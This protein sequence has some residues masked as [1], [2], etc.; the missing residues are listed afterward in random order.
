M[1]P[2][3]RRSRFAP[4]ERERYRVNN[5]IRIKEV[6]LIGPDGEQIGPTPTAEA[7]KLAREADMDLVEV[8]PNSRP[9]VCKIIDYGRFKYEQKKKQTRSRS[10]SSILKEIRVRPKIDVHDLEIK[11]RKAREFL[12][13]GH[14]VQVTCLFRGREMAYQYLGK[15]VLIKVV[16][17]LDD[18]AKLERQPRMEG[19]RMN[20]LLGKR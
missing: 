3:K 5:R 20:L 13:A 1:P 16:E 19:R 2:R 15:E 8:A 9:P 12:E 7:L 11:V 10:A 6:F 18:L 4:P 17:L 14:K